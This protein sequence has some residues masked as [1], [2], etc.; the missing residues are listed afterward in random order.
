MAGIVASAGLIEEGRAQSP[1]PANP[2]ERPA[3]T[4]SSAVADCDQFKNALKSPGQLAP[5]SA[6]DRAQQAQEGMAR[7]AGAG[8]QGLKC[9]QEL[10]KHFKALRERGAKGTWSDIEREMDLVI[11]T[12]R[13]VLEAIEGTGGT[14]E[15]ANRAVTVLDEQIKDII[16][17][18]GKDHPNVVNA[19]KVRDGIAA[20]LEVTRNLKA[21][22][23]N[24]LVDIQSRKAEIVE[25]QGIERYSLAQK[26]LEAMNEGLRV[27]IEELAKIAKPPGS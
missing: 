15:E 4:S 2:A 11:D 26:A 10:A 14:V 8:Q 7:V 20:G 13:N 18:R 27:A 25:Q 21:R 22:L 3:T 5:P 1:K 23:D 12:F 16:T 19:L 6:T 9:A 17:R 24:A